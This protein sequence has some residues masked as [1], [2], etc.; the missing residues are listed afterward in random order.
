[1]E[2]PHGGRRKIDPEPPGTVG[3]LTKPQ[4]KAAVSGFGTRVG[5]DGTVSQAPGPA[6]KNLCAGIPR[7][8]Y[9]VRLL[10]AKMQIRVG[11]FPCR[12]SNDV[13]SF[14]RRGKIRGRSSDHWG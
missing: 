3:C 2:I 10:G 11:T 9:G 8:V 6:K 1:L 4:G 14:G 7:W 5:A 13:R 12:H